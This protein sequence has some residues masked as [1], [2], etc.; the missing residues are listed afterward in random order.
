MLTHVK[1][2]HY[3]HLGYWARGNELG[4]VTGE[5]GTST[6]SVDNGTKKVMNI[7]APVRNS[8]SSYL[9]YLLAQFLYKHSMYFVSLYY[10]ICHMLHQFSIIMHSS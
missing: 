5:S 9:A 3:R 4:G 8:R 2:A 7:R 10:F 1:A 6:T